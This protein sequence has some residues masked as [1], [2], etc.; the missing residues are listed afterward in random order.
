MDFA[1][2]DGIDRNFVR[3]IVPGEVLVKGATTVFAVL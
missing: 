1:G 2:A 3:C